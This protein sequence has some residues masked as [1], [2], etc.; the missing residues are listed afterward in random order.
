MRFVWYRLTYRSTFTILYLYLSNKFSIYGTYEPLICRIGQPNKTKSR[1]NWRNCIRRVSI[2]TKISKISNSAD[3]QFGPRMARMWNS[4]RINVVPSSCALTF[5][6]R[7][8]YA[9][10]IICH[11][12]G[13]KG[14][15]KQRQVARFACTSAICRFERWN[16]RRA[17]GIFNVC[18]L[19]SMVRRDSA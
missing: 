8:T 14:A 2:D 5:D 16:A 1:G 11:I 3:S 17:S 10:R 9:Y 6:S 7:C 4:F 15:H 13:Y 19:E 12:S 18:R